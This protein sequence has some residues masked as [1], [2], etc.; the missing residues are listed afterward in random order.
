MLRILVFVLMYS[1]PVWGATALAENPKGEIEKTI[2]SLTGLDF[3]KVHFMVWTYVEHQ[4]HLYARALKQFYEAGLL[5]PG[6]QIPEGEKVAAL[7]LT[8]NIGPAKEF[9][10]GGQLYH[11]R[12]KLREDVRPVH[13]PEVT[14]PAETWKVGFSIPTNYVPLTDSGEIP[15]EQLESDLDRLVFEFI[16]S[17]KLG[18]PQNSKT[19]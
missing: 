3:N 6:T 12:M 9:C 1:I 7:D 19:P 18:N 11:R 2:S 15:L 5:I 10:E 13:H 17:Y 14:L 16:R 8:L 4:K